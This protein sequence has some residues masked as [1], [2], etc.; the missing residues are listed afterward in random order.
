MHVAV[1][2]HADEVGLIDCGGIR[3]RVGCP[4]VPNFMH[5][6]APCMRMYGAWDA[7]FWLMYVWGMGR[8]LLADAWIGGWDAQSASSGIWASRIVLVCTRHVDLTSWFMHY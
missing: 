3:C 7:D 4:L 5:A 6:H 1:S 2:T 8:V